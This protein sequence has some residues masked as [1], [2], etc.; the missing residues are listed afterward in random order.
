MD[1]P[2][3]FD[4][5][6]DDTR[7]EMMRATYDALVKHGYSALTIQRIGDEFSKSK[8]LIYQH[9][10]GKDDLLVAFLEFLLE[11]FEAEVPAGDDVDDAREGLL[12]LID[13]ALS[14]SIDDEYAAFLG[15]MAALRGQAPYDE[16]YREQF[17]ETDAS[18]REHVADVVRDGIE[19]G[20]FREVDPERTAG[21]V[22]ATV[23]GAQTQY[24]TTGSEE[25]LEAARRELTAYVRTRLVADDADGE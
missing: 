18:F 10:D 3:P 20:R 17:A 16:T 5:A 4:A 9:Y 25:P 2:D 14:D 11:R 19:A 12:A 24:V 13:H 23:H 7:A 21:F 8:S 1:A 15:A 22:A 6:P